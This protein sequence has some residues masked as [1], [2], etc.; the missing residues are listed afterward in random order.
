MAASMQRMIGLAMSCPP[1]PLTTWPIA[2]STI[3][4]SMVARKS[5]IAVEPSPPLPP[6]SARA[7]SA[8]SA[9]SLPASHLVR[10]SRMS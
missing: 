9:L 5:V 2:V 10:L 7:F 8:E 6:D 3:S 4:D 1:T